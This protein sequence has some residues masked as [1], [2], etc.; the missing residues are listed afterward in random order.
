MKTCLTF[1]ILVFAGL[2]T[3]VQ[4]QSPRG[5]DSNKKIIEIRIKMYESRMNTY[6]KIVQSYQN[7]K[8]R[9]VKLGNIKRA[10][11]YDDKI[12]SYQKRLDEAKTSREIWQKKLQALKSAAP[13]SSPSKTAPA[14]SAPSATPPQPEKTDP[15]ASE[16][17]PKRQEA[18]K[19]YEAAITKQY[20]RKLDNLKKHV[21]RLQK[22]KDGYRKHSGSH[23]GDKRLAMFDAQ[24]ASAK[25]RYNSAK[26]KRERYISRYMA[27]YDKKNRFRR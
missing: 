23:A 3:I 22:I 26:D 6:S 13:E 8:A 14:T 17:A 11:A 27:I 2:M 12:A 10:Q 21:G 1:I 16:S 4:A 24:I 20:D 9:Y 18:R 25:K 19:Q 15:A 5:S 7:A